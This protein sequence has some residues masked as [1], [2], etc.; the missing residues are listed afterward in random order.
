M[1]QQVHNLY[2]N[3]VSKRVNMQ[4]TRSFDVRELKA[5]KQKVDN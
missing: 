5:T 2:Q 1:N 3:V 4:F